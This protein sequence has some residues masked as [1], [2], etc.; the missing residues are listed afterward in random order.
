[1]SRL[2]TTFVPAALWR[3]KPQALAVQTST[4]PTEH[5][6]TTI[7]EPIA[8]NPAYRAATQKQNDINQALDRTHARLTVI[9]RDLAE[10]RPGPESMALALADRILADPQA[11]GE[12][13]QADAL[14]AEHLRLREHLEIL[15]AARHEQALE[16]HRVFREVSRKA[17]ES[18]SEAHKALATRMVQALRAVDS[19]QA[20]ERSLLRSLEGLG[21]E[22][23]SALERIS[24]PLI[25]TLATLPEES[26]LS[27]QIKS[28]EQYAGPPMA[29]ARHS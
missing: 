29:V 7:M 15:S 21:Y 5:E 25:G 24:W 19:L 4:P 11:I 20:E 12:Q 8:A 14:R 23:S 1:M 13:A 3:F 18:I 10:R 16:V 9:E 6:P 27:M 28:L 2:S 26:Q 17:C 22:V